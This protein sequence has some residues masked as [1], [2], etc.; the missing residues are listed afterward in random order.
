MGKTKERVRLEGKNYGGGEGRREKLRRRWGY[1][2]E[3]KE[4]TEW[5]MYNMNFMCSY[6]YI[7]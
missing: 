4:E 2:G 3:T 1:R 7:K 5:S 6:D